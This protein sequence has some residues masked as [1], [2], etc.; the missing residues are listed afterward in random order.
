MGTA[1]Y[2][3]FTHES[4]EE[5]EGEV[6]GEE[7]GEEIPSDCDTRKNPPSGLY[8]CLEKG[9]PILFWI[10]VHFDLLQ[11]RIQNLPSINLSLDDQAFPTLTRRIGLGLLMN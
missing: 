11:V 2:L 3:L 10:G 7:G 5:G 6:N 9:L 8:E 4:L 1:A